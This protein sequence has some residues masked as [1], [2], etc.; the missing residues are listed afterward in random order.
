MLLRILRPAYNSFAHAREGYVRPVVMAFAIIF[1][2][3]NLVASERPDS[4][5]DH[6]EKLSPAVV[7][8]STTTV[9]DDGQ[10]MDMPQFPP[11]RHSKNFSKILVII[12]GNG[13][14]SH[15]DRVS[16]LMMKA[17]L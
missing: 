4:F 2:S 6:V 3:T 13:R 9:V 12:I 16:S 14:L 1:V 8:I 17:L 15:L 7:N 5:A 11:G 10:A